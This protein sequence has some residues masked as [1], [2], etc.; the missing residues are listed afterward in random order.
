MLKKRIIPVLL[1]NNNSIVKTI[2]YK[3]PRI[4]GD[5]ISAV[6]IFNQRMADEL[7]ILD[8]GEQYGS[9]FRNQS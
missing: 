8:I 9:T 6:K 3:N 5:A 1:I 7:I 2:R 4:V